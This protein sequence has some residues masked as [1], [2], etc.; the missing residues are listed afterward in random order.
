MNIFWLDN[1]PKKSVQYYN[2]RHVVKMILE[3]TQILC[4]VKH[5][6][7]EGHLVPYRATHQNH[8]CVKWA[9]QGWNNYVELHSLAFDLC[10]EYTFRYGKTHKCFHILER[11][12]YPSSIPILSSAV[13]KPLAMPDQYKVP[14]NPVESYR[15]YYMGDKR[16]LA[17]W[18]NRPVPDW[19]K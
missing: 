4:T 9:N 5:L 3:Y 8:P 1:D 17:S 10:D 18:K 7:G 2:D 14:G 16:H 6:R 12:N 11:L 19:W 15:N 13:P